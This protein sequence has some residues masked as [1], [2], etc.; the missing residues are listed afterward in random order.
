MLPVQVTTGLEFATFGDFLKYLRRRAQLTQ[1]ELSI[2]CGYSAQHISHLENNS[3]LWMINSPSLLHRAVKQDYLAAAQILLERGCNPNLSCNPDQEGESSLAL[4]K[5][6]G[7][8][9]MIELLLRFGANP[10]L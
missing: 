6:L 2:A 9:E 4:A 3:R 8:S 5:R 7:F 1:T 10:D